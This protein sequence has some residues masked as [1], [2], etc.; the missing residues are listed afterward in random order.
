MKKLSLSILLMFTAML[1]LNAQVDAVGGEVEPAVEKSWKKGGSLALNFNNTGLSNWAAGGQSSVALG[2]IVDLYANYQKGKDN[3]TNTLNWAAG[4]SRVG[5][6]SNL[7]K[8]SD[9]LLIVFSKYRRNIKPRWGLAAFAELRTQVLLGNQ[10]RAFGEDSL[11][12]NI[13]RDGKREEKLD[14]YLSNLLSPGYLTTSIGWEYNRGKTF[15]V[16]ATPLAGRATTVFDDEV[17]TNNGVVEGGNLY[18][19][20]FGKSVNFQLGSLVRSGLVTELMENVKFSTTLM[21]FSP[22][23]NYGNIDVTWETLT[24]FKINKFLTTTFSTQML[25]YD[26]ARPKVI[27]DENG[28]EGTSHG[29]QFKH[30]LNIGFLAKF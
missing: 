11:G 30:V 20:D 23:D 13:L 3:W 24:S 6:N 2:S 4:L 19:V 12:N 15:Y 28:Q 26:D 14:N 7:V 22:Y 5:D 1:A 29:I 8:K 21:L 27:I 16:H 9:D 18:G 17:F 25:Y 10:Y